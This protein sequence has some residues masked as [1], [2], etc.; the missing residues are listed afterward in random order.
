LG[1]D[2]TRDAKMEILIALIL[3]CAWFA[4]AIVRFSVNF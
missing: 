1:R 3:A 4:P 2:Q